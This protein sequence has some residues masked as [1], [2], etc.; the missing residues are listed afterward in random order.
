MDVLQTLLRMFFKKELQPLKAVLQLL[1]QL[2]VQ[3]LFLTQYRHLLLTAD[4]LLHRKLFTVV[5]TICLL[6]HFHSMALKLLSQ[7]LITFQ[8]L[9]AQSKKIPAQFTWKLLVIQTATFQTWMQ[10]QQLLTSTDFQLLQTIHLVHHILS[11]HSSMELI[12]L[13]TQQ[14]S[15]QVVTEQHSVVSSQKAVSLT[16]RLVENI[17]TLQLLTQAIMEFL[18]MMQ[19]DQQHLLLSSVQFFFAIQVQQS[20]HSMHSF[21]FRALKL[22]HSVLSVM[23]KTQRRLQNSLRIIHRQKR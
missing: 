20:V 17:L 11:A 9:K 13:F 21:F 14:Q 7:T 8:K 4:T 2:L 1:Q 15:S 19:Q 16:G 3:Q 10:L 18:S 23:Q 12:Q 22:C 5:L 6:T